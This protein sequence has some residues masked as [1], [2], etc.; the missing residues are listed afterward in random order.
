MMPYMLLLAGSYSIDGYC[1]GTAFIFIAY[2]LKLKKEAE[3]ISLKQF[4]ILA[5]L[6]GFLLI[7][8]NMAYLFTGLIVLMLP[9]RKTLQKN[10]KYLPIIIRCFVANG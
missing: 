7:A 10:K 9:I 5:I 1:I 6:Y 2:C 4:I 3:T 8:K